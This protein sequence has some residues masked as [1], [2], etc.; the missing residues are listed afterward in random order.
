MGGE[1]AAVRFVKPEK[2]FAVKTML[3][4]RKHMMK[5][6]WGCAALIL[7]AVIVAFATNVFV[8]LFIIPCMVIMGAMVWM[9]I[10]GTGGGTRD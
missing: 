7:A 1:P 8:L 2:E 4:Q 5:M 9:M 10:G 6:V 3:S